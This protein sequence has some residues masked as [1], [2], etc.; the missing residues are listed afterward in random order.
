MA[1]PQRIDRVERGAFRHGQPVDVILVTAKCRVADAELVVTVRGGREAKSGV[2][3]GHIDVFGDQPAVGPMNLEPRIEGRS[4]MRGRDFAADPFAGPR[5]KRPNVDVFAGKDP[6]VDRDRE[7]NG[8][9]NGIAVN[10]VLH[11]FRQIADDEFLERGR[12]LGG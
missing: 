7:L 10:L 8:S 5:T 2:R 9:G 6:A 1:A 11:D 4:D 12:P 3:T